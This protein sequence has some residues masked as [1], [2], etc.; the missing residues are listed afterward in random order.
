ME[1]AHMDVRI[2]P[3]TYGSGLGHMLELRE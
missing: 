2:W 1:I 3:E